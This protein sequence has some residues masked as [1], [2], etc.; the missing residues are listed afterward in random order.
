MRNPDGLVKV[1]YAT[2]LEMRLGAVS[3]RKRPVMLV[4]AV[5]LPSKV[6]SKVERIAHHLLGDRRTRTHY[7]SE[8]F[9]ASPSVA[10]RRLN[11]AIRVVMAYIEGR[12]LAKVKVWHITNALSR[13]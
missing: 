5:E 6:A 1:G 12:D 9:A 3:T 8:Y 7:G 2:G 13:V 4:R 11:Q 10:S